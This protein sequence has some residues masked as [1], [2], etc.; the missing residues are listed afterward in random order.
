[1]RFKSKGLLNSV[2]Y[3]ATG[4][5]YK[6]SNDSPYKD[7]F[8]W[9][10][11][12]ISGT[13]E[14][15]LYDDSKRSG[16]VRTTRFCDH[17]KVVVENTKVSESYYLSPG[18]YYRK[19]QYNHN[20]AAL[21]TVLDIPDVSSLHGE[22][23]QFFK[24]GCQN[25]E[26][27]LGAFLAELKQ[28][29]RLLP[30]LGTTLSGLGRAL[31]T[32]SV[33]YTLKRFADLHLTYSFGIKPLISDIEA[34][35]GSA[36]A[37]QKKL[38][39]LRKNS[40]KPV[41]VDFSK[42]VFPVSP[43]GT[44]VILDNV[45]EKVVHRNEGYVCKYHAFATIIYDVSRISDLELQLKLLTRRFGLDKPLGTLW[46]LTPWSF[47]IDWVFSIG[48][49]LDRITP[50]VTLP[51][52]FIDLG[53]SVKIKRRDIVRLDRKFPKGGNGNFQA[54]I[55]RSRYVR[56]PGLPV[57]FSSLSDSDLTLRQLALSMSLSLQMWR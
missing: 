32:K 3:T 55:F 24:A 19:A 15:I 37:L 57:S 1:M 23:M 12:H 7:A 30:D 33:K 20:S 27:D 39:F 50:A 2:P 40:G 49:W 25:Q 29:I 18:T 38:A 10:S 13:V 46:E 52:R 22:A 9:S 17:Q 14:S 47:V 43:L 41:R 56:Y 34:L 16:K 4:Q 45:N 53:Y 35:I 36:K 5:D 51:V 21:A 11:P 6:S 26:I 48:Q 42:D 54:G 44:T 31:R 28:G 8:S